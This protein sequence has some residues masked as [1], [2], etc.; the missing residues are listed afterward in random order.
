VETVALAMPFS[1]LRWFA[2]LDSTN[3][4]LLDEAR[5]G[6][7]TGTVVAADHQSAGRGRLGRAWVAPAGASLLTSV[8]LRPE[9]PVERWHALVTTAGLAMAEAVEAATGVVAGLKWPNDLLVGERKLAGVLAEA[10]GE[11]LVIGIGVNVEWHDV[12]AELTEIATA[13]NIEGG[14][15]VDRRALLD[16]FLLRLAAR[17]GDLDDARRAYEARLV[18]IGRTVRVE[19][20]RGDLVGVARGVDDAGHL[21]LDVDGHH[22]TITVG[23]VVHLRA[24]D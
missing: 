24:A 12:P 1:E 4:Y 14:R 8:L 18:T 3:R 16:E 20:P 11:A 13:C 10:A 9:L 23:D 17:L 2:E 7:A 6:A 19:R 21:L 5:A 15:A 22:E